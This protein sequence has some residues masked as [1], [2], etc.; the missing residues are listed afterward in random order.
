M[1]PSTIYGGV[2]ER[3]SHP[4]IENRAKSL[5]SG[6]PAHHYRVGVFR[7]NKRKEPRMAQNLNQK[8]ADSQTLKMGALSRM[9]ESGRPVTPTSMCHGSGTTTSRITGRNGMETA[10]RPMEPDK[11]IPITT[12]SRSSVKYASSSD[13]PVIVLPSTD[14]DNAWGGGS[15]FWFES[16]PS[17]F[18]GCQNSGYNVCAI[19]D[20]VNDYGVAAESA[21]LRHVEPGAWMAMEYTRWRART[22]KRILVG[23]RIAC[24]RLMMRPWRRSGLRISV[25]P[26]KTA[27]AP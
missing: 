22:T 20:F 26:A 16:T 5:N 19:Q 13:R 7:M 25:E 1:R 12:W 21:P 27:V 9:S 3:I 11:A 6:A 8:T 15:S 14:G 10:G 2:V 17:F 24:H 4:V 18:G 23:S